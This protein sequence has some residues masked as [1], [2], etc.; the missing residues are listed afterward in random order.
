MSKIPFPQANNLEL[1][2]NI[3]SYIGENGISK[4]DVISSSSLTT[5]REATYYL[6]A[7]LYIGLVEK[8]KRKYFLNDEG[9]KIKNLP[10]NLVRYAFAVKV[11]E[12]DFLSEL[13][14]QTSRI[15]EKTVLLHYIADSVSEK[16]SLGENTSLRRSS[17]V[18]S[19]FNWIN[20]V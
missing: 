5:E 3:F 19:W 18:L 2:F 7:L 10:K 6:D 4:E 8:I 16:E 11:I 17:T 13:Y 1:V 15:Q 20:Q 9:W 12:D 14:R